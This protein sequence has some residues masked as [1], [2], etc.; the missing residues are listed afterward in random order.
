M[1]YILWCYRAVFKNQAKLLRNNKYEDHFWL[2]VWSESL[3]FP[4][5]SNVSFAK[6]FRKVC[7]IEHLR[8]A[9]SD[10]RKNSQKLKK[11]ILTSWLNFWL[12]VIWLNDFNYSP[13]IIRL[14]Q[15][16]VSETVCALQSVGNFPN[17]DY[18]L[19]IFPVLAF[20]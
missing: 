1:V 9:T 11:N 7:F 6:I 15:H 19:H 20:P 5:C 4:K 3:K 8:A 12:N 2:N 14:L 13:S 10:V 18:L 16:T 17:L